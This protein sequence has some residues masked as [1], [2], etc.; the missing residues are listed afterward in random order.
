MIIDDERK[1]SLSYHTDM[2]TGSGLGTSGAMNVALINTISSAKQT[3]LELLK[4]FQFGHYSEIKG[5]VKTNGPN[6][7]WNKLVDIQRRSF[8]RT[9]IAVFRVC[10]WIENHL[11]LFIIYS[12][13]RRFAKEVWSKFEQGDNDISHSRYY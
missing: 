3:S 4:S 5:V 11:L 1:L 10:N 13:F 2:P 12:C 8:G 9:F 6:S 7:W